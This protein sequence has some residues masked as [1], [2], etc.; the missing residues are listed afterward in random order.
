MGNL[1]PLQNAAILAVLC[2]SGDLKI[3]AHVVKKAAPTITEEPCAAADAVFLFQPAGL[4]FLDRKYLCREIL[5]NA[6][7]AIFKPAAFA[8]CIGNVLL[9]NVLAGCVNDGL[10]PLFDFCRKVD[11]FNLLLMA[12]QP[13]LFRIFGVRVSCS[14]CCCT[15]AALM[16]TSRRP[17]SIRSAIFAATA[18][19]VRL[20]CAVLVR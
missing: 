16:G 15:G 10:V 6:K 8:Q 1:F 2:T 13:C 3:F 11:V 20:T 9:R 19:H 5:L 12:R 17:C 18:S 14:I 7:F 4:I